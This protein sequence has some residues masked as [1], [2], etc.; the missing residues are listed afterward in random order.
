MAFASRAKEPFD[1]IEKSF[2]DEIDRQDYTNFW[3]EYD[4]LLD[5]AVKDSIE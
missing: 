5:R 3:E 2:A 4:R 1:G